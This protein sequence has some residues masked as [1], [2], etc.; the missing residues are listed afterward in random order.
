MEKT[1]KKSGGIIA[2]IAGVIGFFAAIFTLFVGGVGGAVGAAGAGTIVEFGFGGVL[3]SFMVIVFG[4]ISMS[5]T[6]KKPG[7][8]LVVSA[9]LGAY[10][11]GT[12]VAVAMALAIVGGIVSIIG[13]SKSVEDK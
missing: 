2:L 8:M 1:M 12:F 9:V 7:I 10:F 13:V 6:T 4:A 3:F 5:A 11:G